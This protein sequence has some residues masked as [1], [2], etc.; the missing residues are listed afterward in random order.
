M[1]NK[2]LRNLSPIGRL[3]TKNDIPPKI[4][5]KKNQ[6]SNKIISSSVCKRLFSEENE[7]EKQISFRNIFLSTIK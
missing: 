6:I 1:D 3:S 5:T 2:E 4:K 7:L